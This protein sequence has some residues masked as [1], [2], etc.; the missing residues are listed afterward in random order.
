MYKLRRNKNDITMGFWQYQSAGRPKDESER[1]WI[2]RCNF[3]VYI[4]ATTTNIDASN[5]SSGW[6]AKIVRKHNAKLENFDVVIDCSTVAN[7]SMLRRTLMK[8]APGLVARLTSEDFFDFIES[9]SQKSKLNNV[10]ISNRVGCIWV[11]NKQYW[12]FSNIVLDSKCIK[13]DN[14][15]VMVDTSLPYSCLSSLSDGLCLNKTSI[16]RL[17]DCTRQYFKTRSVHA[18]HVYSTTLKAVLKHKIEECEHMLSVT[19]ISGPANIGKTFACCIALRMMGADDLMLSRVTPSSLLDVC[20]HHC[21]M[22]CVWDDPRDATHKHLA[23]IVHE[24]FHGFPNTTVSK[25]VRKYNSVIII[26]TQHNLLG[27]QN[28]PVH[29]PTFSRLAHIDMSTTEFKIDSTVGDKLASCMEG[30]QDIFPLLLGINYS[31]KVTDNFYEKLVKK[32]GDAVI[33]DRALRVAAIEWNLCTQM[34]NLGF[35]FDAK[36]IE[37]YFCNH[38]LRFLKLHCNRMTPLHQFVKDCKEH[39][40]A[41]EST[42]IKMN[43]YA[44]LKCTGTCECVAVHVKSILATL[45]TIKGSLNYNIEGV[46]SEVKDNKEYGELSHN[47]SYKSKNSFVTRRS[48]VI[49]KG[50]WDKFV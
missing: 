20:D 17:G 42:D 11:H 19:N 25:G 15:P 14:S 31:K 27:L 29:T 37:D 8:R 46:Q 18:L 36:Q 50:I 47:V 38:M 6:I 40:H 49:R 9:D 48:M 26:G 35:G 10:F 23:S 45:K 1:V 30:L 39:F 28:L 44:E 32:A 2:P 12:A 16:K 34:N 22:L 21:N 13:I 4:I 7:T 33:I 43:V 5:Q 41:F 3:V 24:A